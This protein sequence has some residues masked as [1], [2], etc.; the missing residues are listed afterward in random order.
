MYMDGKDI[1]IVMCTKI[2]YVIAKE[3]SIKGLAKEKLIFSY[4]EFFQ[5]TQNG[6]MAGL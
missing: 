3:S 4:P 1:C 5:G 6:E 2:L